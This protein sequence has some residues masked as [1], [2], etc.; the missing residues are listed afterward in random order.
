MRTAASR[1]LEPC[2]RADH[3]A[4]LA[5]LAE[6]RPDRERDVEN[7]GGVS[8]RRRPSRGSPDCECFC[9]PASQ[10]DRSGGR[11][12][13]PR[14]RPG[15]AP[16]GPSP[17]GPS[18]S[19]MQTAVRCGASRPSKTSV[20]RISAIP[21]RLAPAARAAAFTNAAFPSGPSSTTRRATGPPLLPQ[22]ELVEEPVPHHLPGV[23][24]HEKVVESL[25]VDGFAR[26]GVVEHLGGPARLA[27]PEA[28]DLVARTRGKPGSRRRTRRAG[29]RGSSSGGGQRAPSSGFR[30]NGP[31]SSQ[32]VLPDR[33]AAA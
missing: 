2:S 19:P 31:W 24:A 4:V 25:P 8:G 29:R 28:V 14:P 9:R 12:A 7:V 6:S 32:I 13:S 1:K 17:P 27:L 10:S 22:F 3:R 23:D 26:V 15:D 30:G 21:T 33:S 16:H 11:S 5:E 20:S 18:R